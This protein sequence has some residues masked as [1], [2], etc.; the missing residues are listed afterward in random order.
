MTVNGGVHEREAVFKVEAVRQVT[1]RHYSVREV[2][3]RLGVTTK[4]LYDWIHR[5]GRSAEHH[6]VARRQDEEIRQLKTELRRVVEERDILKKAAA[7]VA[8]G[9]EYGTCSSRPTTPAMRSTRCV[10]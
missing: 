5:Y 6:Q 9:S 3:E 10:A 8:K 4:S 1:D 2:A 7:Y